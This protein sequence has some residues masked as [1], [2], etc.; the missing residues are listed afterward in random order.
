MNVNEIIEKYKNG[1]AS[2]EETNAALKEIDSGLCYDPDKNV[3]QPEEEE[4]FGLLDTGT[5]TL[6]K[7]KVIKDENGIRLERPVFNPESFKGYALPVAYVEY[8][9]V[10]YKVADDGITLTNK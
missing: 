2:L 6:D 10:W 7:V 8:K 3:I 9:G 4:C 1:E 5:G